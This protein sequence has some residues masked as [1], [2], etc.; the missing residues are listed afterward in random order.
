MTRG[1]SQALWPQSSLSAT[2][3]YP[4]RR[5]L[6]LYLWRPPGV[7]ILPPLTAEWKPHS[8]QSFLQSGLIYLS[9]LAS[10]PCSLQLSYISTPASYHFPKSWSS[11]CYSLLSLECPVFS[12]C[13]LSLVHPWRS[14]LHGI[15]SR[16]LLLILPP[17]KTLL[18]PG[19]LPQ[20]LLHNCYHCLQ[21]SS[22]V[23]LSHSLSVPLD[24][25]LLLLISVLTTSYTTWQRAN[26]ST[27]ICEIYRAKLFKMY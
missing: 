16:T 25:E 4:S 11:G 17:G 26:Y 22:S 8:F 20:N 27:D 9:S 3:P 2:Q 7:C 14:G 10:L 15:S 18:S 19:G 24:R 6:A 23:C 21:S 5:P 12:S 13:W 1:S